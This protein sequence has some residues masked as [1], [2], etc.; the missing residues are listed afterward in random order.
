M[1]P[2]QPVTPLNEGEGTF[3]APKLF[4]TGRQ[5]IAVAVGDLNGDGVP[6][7]AV[8]QTDPPQVSVFFSEP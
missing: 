1:K 3:A 8:S 6:D 7:L 2:V 4:E 5:P